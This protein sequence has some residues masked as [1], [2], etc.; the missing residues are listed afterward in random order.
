MEKATQAIMLLAQELGKTREAVVKELEWFKSHHALAT[1]QDLK[2]MENR[3]VATVTEA[4][5]AFADK[6]NTFND[7]IDVAVTDLQ[8][9]VKT[10]NDL[11]T[12]LQNSAGSISPEDQASLDAIQSRSEAI[13]VK[14]E[15]LDALTPPAPP[16]V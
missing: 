11:I 8:G 4:I 15:A 6:Q 16:V 13:A 12:A 10:L 1:K 3:I 9:D 14:L 7:R 5:K 2:E